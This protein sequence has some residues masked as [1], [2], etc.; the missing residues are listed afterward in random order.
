MGEGKRASAL[1]LC[2]VH[3]DLLGETLSYQVGVFR[4]NGD[5]VSVEKLEVGKNTSAVAGDVL[6]SHEIDP[7]PFAHL[8][9]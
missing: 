3:A 7:A 8:P 5:H 6:L 9:A 2:K 1:P 4:M